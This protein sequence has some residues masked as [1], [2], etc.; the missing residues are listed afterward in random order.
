MQRY[1]NPFSRTLLVYPVDQRDIYQQYCQ[2]SRGSRIDDNPFSSMVDLW[3]TGMSIAA[4]KKLKPV[5]LSSQQTS[6]LIYGSIF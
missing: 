2:S 5:D 6:D 1:Y 4:R 3:F